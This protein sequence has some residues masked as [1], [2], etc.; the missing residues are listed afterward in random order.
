MNTNDQSAC[1]NA[2][3]KIT[4]HIG[5]TLIPLEE[6]QELLCISNAAMATRSPSVK[7]MA[8]K[9]Q[10]KP[11]VLAACSPNF[12]PPNHS[13]SGYIKYMS[14]SITVSD[15]GKFKGQN[16]KVLLG[17]FTSKYYDMSSKKQQYHT[18]KCR[19]T[20]CTLKS[21]HV[22]EQFLISVS[23]WYKFNFCMLFSFL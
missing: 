8:V 17:T 4:L 9:C 16:K 12:T 10:G 20:N 15:T 14:Y 13:F 23:P 2:L 6:L 3:T 1:K 22:L 19:A 18:A 7:N 21:S 11:H 5:I